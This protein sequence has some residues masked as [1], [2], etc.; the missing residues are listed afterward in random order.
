MVNERQE[1]LI[2]RVHVAEGGRVQPSRGGFGD[3]SPCTGVQ[4]PSEGGSSHPSALFVGKGIPVRAV[5][6]CSAISVQ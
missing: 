4:G 1:E 5:A 3:V 6:G 2:W